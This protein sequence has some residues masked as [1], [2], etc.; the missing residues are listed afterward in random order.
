M[1]SNKSPRSSLDPGLY[2]DF[3][4]FPTESYLLP[5]DTAAIV[6]LRKD[7]VVS[8]GESVNKQRGFRTFINSFE[9]D[10]TK[11][12]LRA[13]HVLDWVINGT[14]PPEEV[15]KTPEKLPVKKSD[16]AQSS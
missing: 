3:L 9:I 4:V 12:S 1:A 15:W 11:C 10:T 7:Q 16:T 2:G 8:V 6:C 14:E 5:T 13:N